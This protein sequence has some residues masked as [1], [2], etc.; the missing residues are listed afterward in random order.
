MLFLLLRLEIANIISENFTGGGYSYGPSG[1]R[2]IP[3]NPMAHIRKAK[4]RGMLSA[5]AN[6]TIIKGLYMII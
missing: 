5:F 2:P 3:G 4:M 1:N 6:H